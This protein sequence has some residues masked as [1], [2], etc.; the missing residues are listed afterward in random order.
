MLNQEYPHQVLLPADDV[1]KMHDRVMAFHDEAGVPIRNRSAR[2]DDKWY[3]L[4]CFAD[5]QHALEF[6]LM[7]GG[8]LLDRPPPR[9][10]EISE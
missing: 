7:F 8:E 4:Y 3:L 2:K 10:T 5:R 9:Q 6:R 1:R